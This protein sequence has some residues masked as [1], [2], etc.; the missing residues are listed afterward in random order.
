MRKV[1]RALS[2]ASLA[3]ALTVSQA[4]AAPRPRAECWYEGTTLYAIN[5][6][7]EWSA[8]F[9]LY[10][11]GVAPRPSSFTTVIDPPRDI[12]FWGRGGRSAPGAPKPGAQ[13]N[14]YHIVCF[15]DVP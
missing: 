3:L 13:L 11:A 8:T 6:P 9:Q 15:V 10:P 4:H 7:D 2:A 5:L 1:A 12:Y 14:D